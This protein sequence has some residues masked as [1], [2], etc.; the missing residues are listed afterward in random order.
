MSWGQGTKVFGALTAFVLAGCAPVL[1][2]PEPTAPSSVTSFSA[3]AAGKDFPGGWQPWVLSRH[4][5]P[6]RYT[7]VDQDGRVVVQAHAEASASALVHPLA[8]DPR[9]H[10]L[11]VWRWKVDAL[12]DGA[13]NS[14]KDAED[15]PVRILVS[16]SGDI[17]SLPLA[18]RIFFDNFRLLT[19][20][21]LPYA[22]LIYIWENRLPRETIIPHPHTSRIRMIVAESGRDHVGTWR[23]ITRNVY[24]D[25][26][27]AFGEE[28]GTITGVGIMT[29]TDNT[30][31]SIQAYYGDIE[32]RRLAA[33]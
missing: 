2:A 18:E 32:F 6:T 3:S 28:P 15:A 31:T 11:L 1:Q 23:E 25:Y 9:E 30:G 12:I 14:R 20:R 33:R 4:K 19:G 24:E 13:D 8:V 26:R 27:R 22:T 29:D 5:R 16:F 10:P 21:Q 17:G 7:L